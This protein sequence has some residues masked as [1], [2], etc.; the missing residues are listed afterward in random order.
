MSIVR[1]T[2]AGSVGSLSVA[3][4]ARWL[5]QAPVFDDPQPFP[6]AYTPEFESVPTSCLT[7]SGERA[8]IAAISGAVGFCGGFI[9][10]PTSRQAPPQFSP[11]SRLNMEE[12][13]WCEEGEVYSF[14]TLN[15]SQRFPEVPCIPVAHRP[16][17]VRPLLCLCVPT[18]IV[19][20]SRVKAKA[21]P[22]YK[23]VQTPV[24]FADLSGQ[25][26]L[27]DAEV[28]VHP[29]ID[30]L[31]VSPEIVPSLT[32][33]T[34]LIFHVDFVDFY[35]LSAGLLGKAMELFPELAILGVGGGTTG[36]ELRARTEQHA[37]TTPTPKAQAKAAGRAS[38]DP[39]VIAS[40]RAAGIGEGEIASFEQL[41]HAPAGVS[42]LRS[43]PPP[44]AEDVGAEPQDKVDRLI[45]A[46]T[47]LL[48]GIAR[49][50]QQDPLEKVVGAVRQPVWHSEELYAKILP[51]ILSSLNFVS[52][53]PA[54]HC[55]EKCQP[56]ANTSNIEPRSATTVPLSVG[57]GFL[58]VQETL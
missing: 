54:G 52:H 31:L 45:D 53:S 58:V 57:L 12:F 15:L 22:I 7:I 19:P 39:S 9:T 8:S 16:N 6:T 43:A 50:Q 5:L 25:E 23:R 20:A 13:Q 37:R 36:E 10:G 26:L 3:A 17:G 14:L 24:P 30:L 4:F 2:A 55:P 56:C 11:I 34:D 49:P 46:L 27:D 44:R 51:T 32:L 1:A 47:G 18:G 40:A 48:G 29:T 38:L 21:G 28:P 33:V 41:L 42:A 35:P